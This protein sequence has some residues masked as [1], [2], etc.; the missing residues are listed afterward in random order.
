ML[1]IMFHLIKKLWDEDEENRR[2]KIEADESLIV[3]K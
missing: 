2:R 3:T 1:E